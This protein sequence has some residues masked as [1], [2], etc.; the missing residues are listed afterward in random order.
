MFNLLKF[1]SEA[2]S[3]I[4]ELKAQ[5]RQA[6]TSFNEVSHLKNEELAEYFYCRFKRGQDVPYS[7]LSSLPL[8]EELDLPIVRG[9]VIKTTRVRP[10]HRGIVRFSTQWS[11][12]S[13]L[14]WHY[15]SDANEL[16]KVMYGMVKVFIGDKTHILKEGDTIQVGTGI[17]H[18]ITALDSTLLQ[19]DFI[20]TPIHET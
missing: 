19:V 15:H 5:R 14:T 16:I 8:N 11:A 17:E 2:Q 3:K 9:G 12:G 10:T 13:T 6:V 1:N 4:E 18:Q 20:R 7:L